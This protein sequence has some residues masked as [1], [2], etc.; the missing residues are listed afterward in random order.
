MPGRTT[1][2]SAVSQAGSGRGG[3]SRSTRGTGSRTPARR[4]SGSTR[5]PAARKP[6]PRKGPDLLDKGIDAVGRG[7]VRMGKGFGRAVGRTRELD[8]A[9]RRD[10]L[11][12]ALLVLAVVS[13]AGIWWGAGGPVGGWFS[14]GIG[15]VMGRAAVVLPVVLVGAGVVLVATDA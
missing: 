15:Y 13:A 12:V 4:P 8:P 14:L 10:G 9:H 7:V 6:P 3:S 1:P 5:R 2:N 11:G